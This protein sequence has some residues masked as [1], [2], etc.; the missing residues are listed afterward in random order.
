M[1]KIDIEKNYILSKKDLHDFMLNRGILE[2]QKIQETIEH[3]DSSYTLELLDENELSDLIYEYIDYVNQENKKQKRVLSF[4]FN[5]P[6]KKIYNKNYQASFN[7]IIFFEYKNNQY[8]YWQFDKNKPYQAEVIN[9][10]EFL[11]CLLNNY[12]DLNEYEDYLKY[13]LKKYRNEL[14]LL[15]NYTNK[16]QFE[17]YDYIKVLNKK[18]KIE[19]DDIYNCTQ[20]LALSQLTDQLQLSIDEEMCLY[21]II[22]SGIKNIY[23]N[24]SDL[25]K[26]L[27]KD[28]YYGYVKQ[29]DKWLKSFKDNINNISEK[30]LYNKERSFMINLKEETKRFYINP[31]SD[32]CIV[33]RYIQKNYLREP[34]QLI[35]FDY[36]IKNNDFEIAR[37]YINDEP[38]YLYSRI[39]NLLDDLENL[40]IEKIN[41]LLIDSILTDYN[42]Y[43]N[44]N[45]IN[46]HNLNDLI[47]DNEYKNLYLI[48]VLHFLINY[49]YLLK[50]EKKLQEVE[51]LYSFLK[52]FEKGF[53]IEGFFTKFE[54]EKILSKISELKTDDDNIDVA[55]KNIEDK[56]NESN[57][58]EKFDIENVK[59]KYPHI[60]FDNLDERVK[61]YIATGDTILSIFN[62]SNNINFDYS[63]A[64]IEWSK[65]VELEA[66]NK[67]TSKIK[68]YENEIN[69]KIKGNYF[70]IGDTIGTFSAI[71]NCTMK[72]ERCM[73]EYLFDE[74]YSKIYNFD[75]KEYNEL[76][77]K[78]ISIHKP[79]N[80]SAHK[81][82]S[83][84]LKKA[85][86][87]QTIILSSKKILEILSELIER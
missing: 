78:I 59:N 11:E 24:Y 83:I 9:F 1:N 27:K 85:K 57:L 39:E 23:F 21:L 73:T 33:R 66:Y 37:N 63:S 13:L 41:S 34:L 75:K 56:I 62:D 72:D 15:N 51:C 45:Y 7:G 26:Y 58:V 35:Y 50:S 76:I 14:E 19:Y 30:D 46:I 31:E 10:I 12:N 87:C 6:I 69:K 16:N 77:E 44:D 65:A 25:Y 81:Y 54:Y 84:D 79:R 28:I 71:D 38:I 67:L 5:Y 55:L 53:G 61:K 2:F 82:K 43:K 86:E 8:I 29:L 20:Y 3:A 40:S 48:P 18:E 70:N 36:L 80:D 49:L 47:N 22:F 74:Y 64:V 42:L 4:D 52:T 60:K 32:F 17:N 68:K